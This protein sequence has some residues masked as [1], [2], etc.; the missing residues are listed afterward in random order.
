MSLTLK[1]IGLDE[2][3]DNLVLIRQAAAELGRTRLSI[4]SD[5]PYA[6]GIETGRRRDGRI[7]RRAGGLY[8]LSGAA[9]DVA[10]D[11]T[12]LIV[13]SLDR[14]AAGVLGVLRIVALRLTERARQLEAPANRTDRLRE[15]LHTRIGGR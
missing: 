11:V 6:Y 10:P 7:A 3:F 9:R 14:G 1:L 13:R 8:F 4:G 12:G 15:S 2:S 5:L